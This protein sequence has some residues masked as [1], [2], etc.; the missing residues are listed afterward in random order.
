VQRQRT[1]TVL[2]RSA[3]H[4]PVQVQ[5]PEVFCG[6]QGKSVVIAES[7]EVPLGESPDDLIADLKRMLEDVI[8]SKDDILDYD[9]AANEKETTE[10]EGNDND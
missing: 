10:G 4:L 2:S 3:P 8:R 6:Q 9:D 1:K 5:N 7:P